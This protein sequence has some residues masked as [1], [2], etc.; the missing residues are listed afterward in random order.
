MQKN[1]LIA[2]AF[3]FVVYV[4]T[5]GLYYNQTH[6]IIIEE[7]E[8]NIEDILLSQR[9]LSHLVSDVQKT[10]VRRLQDE[11]VLEKDY[12]SA[13]LLSSSYITI[14]LNEYANLEREKLG[15]K[16]LE[17]K[18]ASPNPT[19]PNN[20]ANL[21][22]LSLYEKFNNNNIK[23][24]KEI[25]NE[26]GKEYLY[27]A[28]AGKRIEAKCLVCHGDPKEAPS[29]LIAT[30]GDQNGFGFKEGDLSSIISM[31]VPLEDIYKDNDRD[32]F[33]VALI[34]LLVFIIL[35]LGAERLNKHLLKKEKEVLKANRHKEVSFQKR[36]EL[37]ESLEKLYGHVISSKFN[38]QGEIIDVSE[39]LC[40]VSGY[41]KEEMIGQ[42]FCFFKHPDMK[43][44]MFQTV[45][46]TLMDGK[47]WMGEVKNL[48]KNGK[49]FWVE[50]IV[51][52]IKDNHQITI[53]FESIMRIITE[54][55]ALLEDINL[56]PLTSLLNRRSFK[57]QFLYEQ[58]RAK[59][60]KK[61]FALM[62]IDIDFFKQY[63]DNY[64]HQQGDLVLQKVAASLQD[65][66]RRSCD[67]V[68]RLGG[69]EFAVIT[70][71]EEKKN[72]INS[73]KNAC[74]KLHQEYI[75]HIK[76]DVDPYLTISIGIAVIGPKCSLG[77]DEI[78]EES[79]K[80]LYQAK[81]NGRNQVIS[82]E[83]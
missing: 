68:F 80:A 19:N 51:H 46:K 3:M 57:R 43:E 70:S 44:D 27:Y 47:E 15:L 55:K 83:L 77:L 18:Y 41:S 79:D 66:F 36:K 59:R 23:N 82:I 33:I 78:Y 21:Y 63:N 14:K 54:K 31:K 64:G 48:T 71:H 81:T 75:P 13:A 2:F 26:D 7:T 49:I 53:A 17:Y 61:Y 62:M 37:E 52:P 25:L 5:M 32:F 74:Y 60:D 39:A 76:S 6:S 69:E 42:P 35:F 45:W 9:A 1:H 11:G 10:E 58:S 65:S 12:F 73:A 38:T 28:I 30:Y 22:E 20:M 16:P 29:R 72:L 50:A 24:F 40:N 67:I 4:L 34:I 56:D 8:H